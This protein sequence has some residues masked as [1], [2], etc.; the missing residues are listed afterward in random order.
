MAKR[1]T[2]KDVEYAVDDAGGKERIFRSWD[3]ACGFACAVAI[4][5][6]R[7]VS[8]DILVYSKA[9]ARHVAGDDGVEMY[10]EDPE[11]SVF[12]RIEITANDVGRVA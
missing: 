12:S 10:N 3:E 7:D 11:A 8:V 1:S 5:G 6:K 4:S 9:G 2:H